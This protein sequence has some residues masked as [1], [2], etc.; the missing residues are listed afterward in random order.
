MVMVIYFYLSPLFRTKETKSLLQAIMKSC[1]E[2][3][4]EVVSALCFGQETVPENDLIE[5]LLN[6][7]FTEEAEA[8]GARLATRQ[9]TLHRQKR[10]ETPVIRSYLLQL[11]LGRK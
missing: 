3:L 4:I 5:M 7:I 1:D 10:D 6:F 2:F 8:E 9:M 11:L